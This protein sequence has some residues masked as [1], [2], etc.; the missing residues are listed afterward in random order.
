M[1]RALVKAEAWGWAWYID[2]S[3]FAHARDAGVLGEID[4][5]IFPTQVGGTAIDPA[6]FVTDDDGYFPGWV[7]YG[8]YQF[9]V[10]GGDVF[11]VLAGGGAGSGGTF[12]RLELTDADF[13]NIAS[14]RGEGIAGWRV[15]PGGTTGPGSESACSLVRDGNTVTWRGRIEWLAP[16]VG[17]DITG[18]IP[19]NVL[20]ADVIPADWLPT[21]DVWSVGNSWR[22]NATAGDWGSHVMQFVV[23]PYDGGAIRSGGLQGADRA[24]HMLLL[25]DV[26]TG[27]EEIAEVHVN[28]A[29][30]IAGATAI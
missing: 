19:D 25:L 14:G 3:G 12:E 10:D 24:P 4:T 27:A 22:D 29:W 8:E 17:D 21:D 15:Q 13:N 23:Q 9:S 20:N 2:G 30:P 7:E 18:F 11:T 6:D 28:I 1:P 5:D 16:L 26:A